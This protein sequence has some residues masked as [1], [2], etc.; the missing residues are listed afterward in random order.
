MQQPSEL[1]T[2]VFMVT[3]LLIFARR[4]EIDCKNQKFCDIFP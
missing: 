1:Q 2:A 4:V 3:I